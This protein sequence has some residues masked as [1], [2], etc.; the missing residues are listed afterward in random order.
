LIIVLISMWLYRKFTILDEIS[1]GAT[2][3]DKNTKL[4]LTSK[5]RLK[6]ASAGMKSSGNR[7][8][9]SDVSDL[10]NKM[11]NSNE[12]EAVQGGQEENDPLKELDEQCKDGDQDACDK[13]SQQLANNENMTLNENPE[14]QVPVNSEGQ[15]VE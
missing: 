2:N 5:V 3:T 13:Y 6:G 12:A 9:M 14:G 8:L 10:K 1:E 7:T 15:T 4:D 11:F